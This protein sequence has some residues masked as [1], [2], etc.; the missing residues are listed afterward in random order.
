MESEV[1]EVELEFD[2]ESEAKIRVTEVTHCHLH[3]K[4]PRTERHE[5]SKRKLCL[6][7]AAHAQQFYSAQKCHV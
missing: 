4:S 5:R 1:Y 3:Y 2:R 7:S 6:L